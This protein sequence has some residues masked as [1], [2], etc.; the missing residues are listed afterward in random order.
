[1]VGGGFAGINLIKSLKNDKRFRI[2]LV[3]KINYHFFPPLIYQVAT[4]FIE[5]SNISFPIRK[6]IS[7]YHNVNFH[8][9]SLQNIF[10]EKKMIETETGNLA[11]DYLVLA[12]GTESNFFG[13]ENV[14]KC[15]LPMKNIEEALY[16]R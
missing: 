9:G 11:Y 14:Q 10:H 4:S 2:T 15:A 5:A 3:D 13:L 8:M 6:F 1:I 7:S 12:L 16:L